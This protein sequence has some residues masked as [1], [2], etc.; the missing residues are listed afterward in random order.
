MT[1][2]F[3][4][5][6][7]NVSCS[8]VMRQYVALIVSCVT[9]NC[10]ATQRLG[11]HRVRQALRRHGD[12]RDVVVCVL[13]VVRDA[14]CAMNQAQTVVQSV[15]L[16]DASTIVRHVLRETL[17][18]LP[19]SAHHV[20]SRQRITYPH[21]DTSRTRTSIHHVPSRRSIMYPH[22]HAS[23]RTASHFQNVWEH[24]S[25]ALRVVA[26]CVSHLTPACLSRFQCVPLFSSCGRHRGACC[27]DTKCRM[28]NVFF[29][30][31]VTCPRGMQDA[32]CICT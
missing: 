13:D 12:T 15:L 32:D 1:S 24:A 29:N 26:F 9:F 8:L 7:R 18:S 6:Q 19:V 20:P 28:F 17:T 5:A 3:C 16:R 22:V 27:G 2:L 14:Y 21:V 10:Q 31:F 30:E 4:D 25:S 23:P 11:S